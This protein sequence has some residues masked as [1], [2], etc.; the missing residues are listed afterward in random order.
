[1]LVHA[2]YYIVFSV[3]FYSFIQT[4]TYINAL[5]A[6]YIQVIAQKCVD[7]YLNVKMSWLQAASA[8]R[9]SYEPNYNAVIAVFFCIVLLIYS[10]KVHVQVAMC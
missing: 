9:N 1:M 6:V 7:T 8:A 10:V 2:V 5:Q 4:Y 3:L